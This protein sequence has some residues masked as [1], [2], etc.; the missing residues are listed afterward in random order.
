MCGTVLP[1]RP[2]SVSPSAVD[3]CLCHPV[4]STIVCH[5]VLS[6]IVCVTQCCRRL[7]VSRSVVDHSLCHPVLPRPA[8]LLCAS[9]SSL[10][11]A[12]CTP[13]TGRF[14]TTRRRKKWT[15]FRCNCPRL[16]C[17][18]LAGP[19]R[20]TRTPAMFMRCRMLTYYANVLTAS[21]GTHTWA[22]PLPGR[23][24]RRSVLFSPP[25][26]ARP[27]PGTCHLPLRRGSG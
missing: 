21:C 18:W 16:V 20:V 15:L 9:A 1:C 19:C 5:S 24:L 2:L 6:T 26:H 13:L 14:W 4:Q 8:T 11:T 3:H 12:S 17:L 10:H 22:G 23:L 7:S 25:R 27:L